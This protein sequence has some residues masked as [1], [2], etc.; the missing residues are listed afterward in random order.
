MTTPIETAPITT[1][2]PASDGSDDSTPARQCGRCRLAFPTDADT[3]PWELCDWWLCPNCSQAL[4][5]GRGS[6]VAQAVGGRR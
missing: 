6:V 2:A 3:H 4:V 5:S 1:G